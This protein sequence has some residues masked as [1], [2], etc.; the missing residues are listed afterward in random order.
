MARAFA[1]YLVRRESGLTLKQ[2]ASFFGNRDQSTIRHLIE[3]IENTQK[4]DKTIKSQLN[5]ITEKIKN[6]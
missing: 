3:K 1:V 2:I 4:N 5:L 6:K